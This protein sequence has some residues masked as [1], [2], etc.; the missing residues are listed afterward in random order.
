M[1][2]PRHS[3]LPRRSQAKAGPI[4]AGMKNKYYLESFIFYLRTSAEICGKKFSLDSG[5]IHGGM[6]AMSRRAS[7]KLAPT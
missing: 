3:G 4:H 5:S 1:F 7:F 6:T 2:L